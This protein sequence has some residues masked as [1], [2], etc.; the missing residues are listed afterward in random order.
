MVQPK[1]EP[2]VPD[3]IEA[4]QKSQEQHESKPEA[5]PSE[6]IIATSH[7]ANERSALIEKDEQLNPVEEKENHTSSM[8][9]L[10]TSSLK[11]DAD[12]SLS[13][14]KQPTSYN[15]KSGKNQKG[16]AL[17][18]NTSAS[19]PKRIFSNLPSIIKPSS[20]MSKI[21]QSKPKSKYE[22]RARKALRTITFILGA[23]V[24][25]WAPYHIVSMIAPYCQ[26][27][28]DSVLFMHFYRF[29]YFLCYLNSPINPFCYAMANQ[30]FKK[31]FLRILKGD[32]RRN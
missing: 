30:Q 5:K 1:L 21:N 14:T 20:M 29:T 3:P 32:W 11:S 17:D 28:N 7:K 2:S 8:G 26:A 27:C 9:L 23:F 24:F 31:T 19:V 4:I 22:N 18:T 25:S 10:A 15:D 13:G 16:G 12:S 6:A